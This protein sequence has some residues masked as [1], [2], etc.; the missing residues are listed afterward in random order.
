MFINRITFFRNYYLDSYD[1]CLEYELIYN[2]TYNR[3]VSFNQEIKYL[4][5]AWI[6]DY[7]LERIGIGPDFTLRVEQQERVFDNSSN[8]V[9]KDFMI[10]AAYRD[11]ILDKLDSEKNINFDTSDINVANQIIIKLQ[12]FQN[13]KIH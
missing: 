10:E 9:Y 11:Y 1:Q 6:N 12:Q 4:V 3:L 13:T 5:D 2:S 8:E 7:E